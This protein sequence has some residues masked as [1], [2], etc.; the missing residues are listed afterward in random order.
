LVVRWRW[1]PIVPDMSARG[2][3]ACPRVWKKYKEEVE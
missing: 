2:Q 1:S 3:P